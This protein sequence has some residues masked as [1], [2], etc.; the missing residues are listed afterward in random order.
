MGFADIAAAD[1]ERIA[2]IEVEG[3]SITYGEMADR[4]N[5]LSHAFAARGLRRGQCV[6]GMF[7]NRR[8]YFEMRLAAGQSGLY[9]T[10]LSHHLTAPE[11]AYIVEDS[12]AK[13]I[14][15]DG[16]LLDVAGDALDDIGFAV[17][18]RFAL[19]GAGWHDYEELL[20]SFPTVVPDELLAG[21][22]MGYTSGTTG[23]PKAVRKLLPEGPPR[24]TQH[25]LDYM[26][27]L[28]IHPGRSVHLVSAPLY[29]A[30]PGTY[31][32]IALSLG[33][34]VVVAERPGPE[35]LLELIERYQV[36]ITVTVPTVLH[37][38]LRL[39]EHVRSRYDLSSLRSLVH[40]AA[41]CPVE[42]KR[43]AIEWLGPVV[44]EYYGAT[45]GVAA[46]VTATEWLTKPGTVG[47]PAPNIE[48]QIL[49]Q[50]GTPLPPGD[51]GHV[52]F[53]LPRPVEYYKDSEKTALAMHGDFFTAGD[54]GYLDRDGWLF[55]CDRRTDLIVSGGVNLYPAEI[56]A[57]L[58][59]HPD[60]ADAA[61][62]GVP[63][64]EWG[65]RAVA[66][67]QPEAAVE[68]GAALAA[69]LIEHCRSM[70]AGYK[71]PRTVEFTAKI[72]RSDAGK[73]QR[74]RLRDTYSPHATIEATGVRQLDAWHRKVMPPVEE[75]RP[76]LWSIP[77]PIPGNPLRYTLV[78]AFEVPGGVAVV[79]PGWECEPTWQ[80]LIAGLQLV[81]YRPTDVR[82]VLVTHVHPDHFGLAQRLRAVS[83]AWIGMNHRDAALVAEQTVAEADEFLAA[84]RDQLIWAGSP[85][86]VVDTQRDF[87]FT[88]FPASHGPEVLI[89]DDG[90]L[91]LPGWN[92]Q[93][94]WT[95]GHTPGHLCFYEH[96]H[97]LLLSGDHVLPRISPN[98][99]LMPKQI[100]DP[101]GEYV[102]SLRLVAHLEPD[103]IL[104][105]HEYRFRGLG[106]RVVEL[107]AHHDERLAEVEQTVSQHPGATCWELTKRLTWSRPVD[108]LSDDL[109][110]FAVRET[111]AHLVRLERRAVLRSSQDTVARWYPAADR[112]T[113]GAT[114]VRE[115]GG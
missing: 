104:P 75:V 7:P 52:Y 79:D 96:T 18:R 62:I 85:T 30:G 43:R 107:I 35:G 111:L 87:P 19:G 95:P 54:M 1:P 80:A 51:V 110:R 42:V 26:A 24:I 12:E 86:R 103:E 65:Q 99:S 92:L 4:V 56:E 102:E 36:S 38:L 72:P 74:G 37:R 41:P 39:P 90:R 59:S 16:S 40:G 69:R 67:V 112:P 32:F 109:T 58:L 91:D 71:V 15:V 46:A 105:A 114:T 98:I 66:I 106:D 45:E 53:T 20:A 70:L 97:K 44:N 55:L 115:M 22:F 113:A 73:L 89:A 34:T 57:A 23:R 81:G 14:V 28:D 33:H 21:D 108:I 94:I 31:S 60:V 84:G 76:G 88:R 2:V 93:A 25:V 17:D 100:G 49:D 9:F 77:V 6:A 82:A 10:P 63:D 8:T 68:P 5:Q 64:D 78:Y 48:V 50:S 61:A 101:L 13:M 11:V 47:R 3:S 27:R 83:G 29:H